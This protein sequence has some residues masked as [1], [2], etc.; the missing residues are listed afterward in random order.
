MPQ[1]KTM[2]N[3]K[4]EHR[5]DKAICNNKTSNHP[6]KLKADMINRL[7]RIEGQVRG[8]SRM[9]DENVYC[10]NVLHQILS[11]E[12]A[13]TGVKKT[14]LE[15]HMKGCVLD[16]IRKGDDDVIEELMVTMSKM[17]K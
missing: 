11:V 13:L 14:L 6:E 15:A 9:I 7:S 17:M 1:M 3:D 2:Q 10:D 16:Q 4:N 8:L 12:S 5:E